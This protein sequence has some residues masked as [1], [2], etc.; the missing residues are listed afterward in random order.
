MGEFKQVMPIAGKPMVRH[1]VESYLTAGL[2]LLV[3]VGHQPERVQQ[4]LQGLP[5]DFVLNT[6]FN[7]GMFTSV[8]AGCRRIEPGAGCLLS[9]CDCPGILPATIE[10]IQT[11]L[12]EHPAKVIIPV[13]QGR[14]G[15]PVGLPAALIERI[16]TL[17]ADTPGVNSLWKNSPSLLLTLEVQDPSVVRDFDTPEDVKTA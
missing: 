10:T 13:F 9:P 3:V 11:T 2:D 16:C 14:R 17:P 4:A 7:Q 12:Q 15:H 5:C 8:Q 6:R 1:L